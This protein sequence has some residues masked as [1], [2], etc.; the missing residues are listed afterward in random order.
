MPPHATSASNPNTSGKRDEI[1]DVRA[2][3]RR[4]GDEGQAPAL[5]HDLSSLTVAGGGLPLTQSSGRGERKWQADRPAVLRI[6]SRPAKLRQAQKKGDG[7]AQWDSSTWRAC[8]RA[9]CS[10]DPFDFVVR[11]PFS[12]GREDLPALL[13]DF[14]EVRRPRQLSA[15]RA[16]G[17]AR[18]SPRSPP[19]SRVTRLRQEIEDKFAIDLAGR[20]TMITVRGNSDGK[21]GRIHTD[22][23]TKLITLL[24]YLNPVW[25]AEGGRLRLLRRADDLA[26]CVAEIAPLAG[27]MVAFRR[28][29][30]SFHGHQPHRR[31]AARAPAQLGDRPG[32]LTARA[33]PPR[34]V[35][36]AKGAQSLRVRSRSQTHWQAPPRRANL[37]ADLVGPH[38][39]VRR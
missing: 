31:R 37:S 24:L 35:G 5:F 18:R 27:T 36:A 4:P 10:R 2:Q 22:S 15:R 39:R 7:A 20:P 8:G 30:A 26:D 17:C 25:E 21:D 32:C 33:R 9:R 38:K 34:L 13:A 6:G 12:S 29:A 19:S 28:S 16:L 11:R 1:P 14:P 3:P 23:A